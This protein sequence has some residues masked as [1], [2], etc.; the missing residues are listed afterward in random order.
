ML[1]S[2]IVK[3]RGDAAII[4]SFYVITKWEDLKR[5]LSNA[6]QDR[7]DVFTLTIE[8]AEMKQRGNE[9]FFH[10]LK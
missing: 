7:R 3:T 8:M 4:I 6:D 2:I 10:F 5:A 1:S 9:S